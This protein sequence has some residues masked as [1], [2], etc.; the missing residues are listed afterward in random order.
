MALQTEGNAIRRIFDSEESIAVFAGENGL[1]H[2]AFADTWLSQQQMD[3]DS[4]M[5]SFS[6]KSFKCDVRRAV[7][8]AAVLGE[9]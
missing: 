7:R 9:R 3:S 2:T 5:G 8:R 1:V 6:K 4:Y